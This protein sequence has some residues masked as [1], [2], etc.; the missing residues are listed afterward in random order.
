MNGRA[1]ITIGVLSAMARAQNPAVLSLAQAQEI[2]V[3]NHPRI[4]SA[5][6]SADASRSAIKEVRSAYYPTLYGNVTGVGAEHGSTLSAGAVTTSSIYSRASSGI[7]ASQLVTDFGRIH[8]LE[9]SAKLHSASEDQN[10]VN[11]RA[12]VLIDVKQAYYQAL[13]AESV[14]EAVQEALDLRRLTLRQVTALAQSALRSTVDVS[15]AQVNLSQA[16]LDLFHAQNDSRASHA[17]LSAAMGYDRDQPFSL[18]DETLPAALNPDVDALIAEAL[19]ERPDLV[20]LRLNHDSLTRYAEAEKDLRNPT[21]SAAAA[22]GIAPVHDP[23]IQ[24]TYTGAGVNVN[25]PVLN[26]GLFKARREEAESRAAAADKDVATLSV[27]ISRDV[28]VAWLDANDAFQRLGV[29]AR[30]VAEAKEALRLAQARYDNALGSIVELSQAQLNETN[31]EIAA[32]S[33]KYDYLNR[34]ATLDF[35]IGG[36]R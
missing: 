13:A 28:R 2:A 9:Q 12:E 27:Q 4:A 34:R 25:I 23:R 36:L 20:A 29:T 3:K 1:L 24:E 26:G 35:T 21:I 19:R 10:V 30:M 11:T 7:V 31:A 14:L 6:L 16:E 15:F 22:A 32:A 17:R 8:S 5:S 18:A 33:A